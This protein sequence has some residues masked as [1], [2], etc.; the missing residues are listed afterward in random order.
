MSRKIGQLPNKLE[1]FSIHY[2][3]KYPHT[4]TIK[5]V[6]TVPISTITHKRPV[7]VGAGGVVVTRI[8]NAFIDICKQMNI[9]RHHFGS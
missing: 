9:G 7:C 3:D 1:L 6:A 5:S 8:A 2:Y 4:C